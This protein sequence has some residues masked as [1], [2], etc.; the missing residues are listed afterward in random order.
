MD[1]KQ[2]VLYEISSKR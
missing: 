2:I 1:I